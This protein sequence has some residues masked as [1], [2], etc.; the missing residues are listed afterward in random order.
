MKRRAL[1]LVL[2]L[3]MLLSSTAIP[4]FAAESAIKE[5]AS[6]FYYI[7]ATPTQEALSAKDKN[8]FIVVDGLY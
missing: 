3:T 7:E 6:G 5:S 1:A 8:L 2:A 4:V